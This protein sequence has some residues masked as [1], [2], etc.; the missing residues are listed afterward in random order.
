MAHAC[1]VQ[2]EEGFVQVSPRGSQNRTPAYRA[3]FVSLLHTL[4]LD[5]AAISEGMNAQAVLR[6]LISVYR[7]ESTG[8]NVVFRRVVRQRERRWGRSRAEGWSLRRRG[9]GNVSVQKSCGLVGKWCAVVGYEEG[10][11]LGCGLGALLAVS[12][13]RSHRW[14]RTGWRGGFTIGGLASRCS[15]AAMQRRSRFAFLHSRALDAI[16]A[17]WE[18]RP[19]G[20]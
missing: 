1:L 20:W 15:D 17:A 3:G 4:C 6:Y 8:G 16:H 14:A 11:C 2:R 19:L 10:D 9:C 18:V 7:W 12:M 5:P 13:A